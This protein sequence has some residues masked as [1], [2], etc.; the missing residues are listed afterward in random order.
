MLVKKVY[1]LRFVVPHVVSILFGVCCDWCW[2]GKT[3]QCAALNFVY[4]C[5]PVGL[6]DDCAMCWFVFVCDEVVPMTLSSDCNIVVSYSF[7]FV[8]S[9]NFQTCSFLVFFLSICRTHNV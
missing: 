2:V 8:C 5:G 3:V 9:L 7:L 6:F 1:F 4:S